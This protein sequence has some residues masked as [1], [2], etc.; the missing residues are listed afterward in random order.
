VSPQ[1]DILE[2]EKEIK[3]RKSKMKKKEVMLRAWEL[4]KAGQRR[5]GGKVVEY[6][7]VALKMAWAE[8]RQPKTV[9]FGVNHQ[10]SG[11]R[12]WVAEI[13]GR[14]PRFKFDRV[15]LNAAERKWSSSGKTGTTFY[16]LKEGCI[17]EVNEPWNGRY[18]VAVVG[19]KIV[20]V[21]VDDVEK[22]I[23]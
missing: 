6:L 5:F 20:D 22:N 4:A 10:P 8:A 1:D 13:V 11:G 23:A 15:F 2:S 9:R 18:F 16:E 19:G 3:R 14:H 12:E 17:Y 21:T 7:S